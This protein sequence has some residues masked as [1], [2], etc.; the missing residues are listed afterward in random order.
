MKCGECPVTTAVDLK[1][2][3][4][5]PST[6][7]VAALPTAKFLIVTWTEAETGA[8][9]KV[10]GQSKYHFTTGKENNFTPLVLKDLAL[11]AG[12]PK[13]TCH[14]YFFQTEVNGASVVLL[15][16]EYHPKAQPAASESFFEQ[17]VGKAPHHYQF[18]ITTGTSGGIWQIIDVGDVVVTN[19]ARYGLTLSA[20]KQNM[21]F[22]GLA[23]IK[24][25]NPPAGSDSWYDY[26][27]NHIIDQDTCVISNLGAA[28][29]RKPASGKPKIYYQAPAGETTTVV[30]NSHIT[31]D[32]IDEESK[33][34][35]QYRKMGATLDENDAFV[36]EACQAIGFKNWVSIRNV[37]DLP[38]GPKDQYTTFGFCSSLNGAYAVWAFLMGH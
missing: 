37:S 23:N 6:A 8:L 31:N 21:H 1:V 34:L 10:L 15:K 36:A 38:T 29:G 32:H 33:N 25:S 11:P 4:A 35:D 17:V 22:T 30:T 20:E 18:L 5:A 13:P 9:A 26:V 3:A 2:S 7:T 19:L 27:N 16:S 12:D 28:D 14:G 24:G